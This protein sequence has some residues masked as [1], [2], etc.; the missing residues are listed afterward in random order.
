MIVSDIMTREVT[1]VA[2]GAK[3][4]DAVHLMAER[5][6]SGLPVVDKDGSV[7]GLLTE[8]DLLRRVEIGTLGKGHGW[9]AMIFLPATCACDYVRTHARSVEMLMSGDVIS[10]APGAGLAEA[11]RLM[12]KHRIKRLPV[13]EKGRLVGIVSRSDIIKTLAEALR[14][15]PLSDTELQTRITAELAKQ[16]WV[17]KTCIEATVQNGVVEF[18][19]T[20]SGVWQRD[21]L[22]ALAEAAGAKDV[23][24]NLV[25]ADPVGDALFG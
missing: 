1:S 23:R 14:S 21:A 16:D 25:L 7:V 15:R 11:A 2:P 4:E 20:I 9:L 24:E 22:R 19:G 8:G 10:I 6:L 5:R 18:S 17:P 3:L 13:I 12:Q